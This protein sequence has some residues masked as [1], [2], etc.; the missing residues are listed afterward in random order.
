MDN[1]SVMGCAKVDNFSV[2]GEKV[3]NFSVEGSFYSAKTGV[4][5]FG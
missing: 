5:S 4:L 1:F 3:D 2:Q